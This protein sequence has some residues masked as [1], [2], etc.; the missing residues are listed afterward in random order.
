MMF[1]ES[2]LERP[3]KFEADTSYQISQTTEQSTEAANLLSYT[4][5]STMDKVKVLGVGIVL[6]V[7]LLEIAAKME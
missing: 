4:P 7:A 3:L 6:L 1:I 2:A 5:E